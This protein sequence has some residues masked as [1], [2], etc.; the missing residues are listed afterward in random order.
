MNHYHPNV[1]MLRN[2]VQVVLHMKS[3]NLQTH[4]HT[5]THTHARTHA[6]TH[7]HTHTHAHKHTH[8]YTNTHT[9]TL[10]PFPF[11]HP[12]PHTQKQSSMCLHA[13]RQVAGATKSTILAGRGYLIAHR[14]APIC[15]LHP[16]QSQWP[17]PAG[18]A[19]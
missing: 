9:F 1:C 4:T 16:L 12:P 5:H 11:T 14:A 10:L 2:M 18:R 8:R 13:R 6:R 15:Y 7:T 3:V 19:G 17:R